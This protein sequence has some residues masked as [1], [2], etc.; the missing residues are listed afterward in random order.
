ML[1]QINSLR[2][3]NITLN[4]KK[5]LLKPWSN[6]QLINFESEKEDVLK[7][8]NIRENLITPNIECKQTLTLIEE[9]MVLVELYKLSKSNIIDITFTCSKC[10]SPSEHSIFIDKATEFKELKTRV[11][12]TKDCI[13]N[14]RQYSLYRIDLNKDINTET[15]RYLASFIDSIEYKG[16]HEGFEL[17]EL[18]DWL[19]QELDKSNFD[20]LIK[21]FTEVQP[22]IDFDVN[23]TCAHC[24]TKQKLN[25]K[26]VEDFLE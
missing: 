8:D 18:V 23:A 2:N 22:T 1:P 15:I 10:N 3:K 24:G 11:I 13:F 7:I 12:K 21:K 26:G 17:D 6:L 25:F 16:T 20:T 9:K 4:S 14:L 19:V 5:I